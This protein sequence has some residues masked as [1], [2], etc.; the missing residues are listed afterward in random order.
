MVIRRSQSNR[1]KRIEQAEMDT[2]SDE[3]SNAS[4]SDLYTRSHFTET[5][6]ISTRTDERDHEEIKIIQRFMDVNREIGELT[7]MVRAVTEKISNNR[8]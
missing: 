8:E 4:N 5:N 2:F 3:K 1:N 6:E 7:I